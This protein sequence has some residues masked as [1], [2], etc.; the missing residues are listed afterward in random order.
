[1]KQIAKI[2]AIVGLFL[3]MGAANAADLFSDA[4]M[5][6]FGEAWNNEPALHEKLAKTDFSS[7]ICY[8]FKG[9]DDPKGCLDVED[10]KVTSAGAYSGEEEVDWDLRGEKDDWEKGLEEGSIG[11]TDFAPIFGNFKFNKG[12]Y[13]D[14]AKNP[15]RVGPF[16]KSFKI[17]ATVTVEED[18]TA[19][20]ATDNADD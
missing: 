4:W 5:K 18:D 7:T 6:A 9:E 13:W 3:Y 19:E 15:S 11:T 16:M 1:M 8:G 12:N 20:E 10:G 17:M 14:M 2:A